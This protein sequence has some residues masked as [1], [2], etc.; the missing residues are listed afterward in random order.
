MG[1]LPGRENLGGSEPAPPPSPSRAAEFSVSLP[2]FC[3]GLESMIPQPVLTLATT[4]G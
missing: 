4:S 3:L 2:L 1:L